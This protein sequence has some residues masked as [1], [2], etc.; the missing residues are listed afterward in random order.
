MLDLTLTRRRFLLVAGGTTATAAAIGV[1]YFASTNGAFV[2][3]DPRLEAFIVAGNF[4][5]DLGAKYL[6]FEHL[7][8][9]IAY[10]FLVEA[11][12]NVVSEG[13]I[14]THIQQQVVA[15][16]ARGDI[17][18][19][20][21]WQLSLTECRLAAIAFLLRESGGHI[22]EPVVRAEGPLD[23]LPELTIVQV[24][25]WG[26]R[27]CRT[28]ETFNLQP[29]GNSALWFRCLKLDRYPDYEIHLGSQAAATSINAAQNLITA[30]L[31][32]KQSRWL[33]SMEG[34]IPIHLVDPV[35]GKQL[36]GYFHVQPSEN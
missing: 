7:R 9:D 26:P 18:Q 4:S 22:E 25:R 36:I 11:T 10:A 32:P 6:E 35:R 2:N 21:G 3:L 34:K 12:V 24:E 31:T 30:S 20:D 5:P 13:D 23:H 1:Y 27:S 28:G 15:D 14:H 19:L 8:E 33:T 16:F 29:N 17:C